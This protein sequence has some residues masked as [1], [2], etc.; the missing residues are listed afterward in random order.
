[1]PTCLFKHSWQTSNTRSLGKGMTVMISADDIVTQGG[2][3]G[4]GGIIGVSSI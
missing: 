4:D 2:S 1:M 3:E